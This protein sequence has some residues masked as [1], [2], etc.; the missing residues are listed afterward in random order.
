M[1]TA[2]GL[3]ACGGFE[4]ATGGLYCCDRTEIR[5]LQGRDPSP[6]NP[7]VMRDSQHASARCQQ[8]SQTPEGT[9]VRV[10]NV[11]GKSLHASARRLDR[12]KRKI[13][14]RFIAG[15]RVAGNRSLRL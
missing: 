1:K 10:S 14:E 9:G 12:Q 3:R 8:K 11:D 7:E 13:R 5:P 2:F 6:A 15:L 4:R